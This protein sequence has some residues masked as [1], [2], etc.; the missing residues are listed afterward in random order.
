MAGPTPVKIRR[1]TTVNK[2]PTTS[3]ITIGEL[4]FNLSDRKAFTSDGSNVFEVGANVASKTVGAN[5]T[6]N[7]FNQTF[8]RFTTTGAT[9]INVDSWATS[10]WRSA[11]YQISVVDNN[12]NNYLTASASMLFD[13]T[14]ATV[15][16]YGVVY[17]NTY[18]G[19]FTSTANAT[20]AILQFTPVSTNTT[21]SMARTTIA[22]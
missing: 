12:A 14:V 1:T 18:M 10:T 15:A 2:I 5:S 6:V 9:T 19:T 21:L 13:G 17:S 16:V 8:V 20:H 4:S 7:G 11:Q 3:D 22:V